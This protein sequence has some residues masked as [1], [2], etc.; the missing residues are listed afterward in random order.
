MLNHTLHEYHYASSLIA[1]AC[2]VQLC[3]LDDHKR[4][5]FDPKSNYSLCTL[6]KFKRIAKLKRRLKGLTV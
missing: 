2:R 4:V 5:T 3:S 6:Q 1:H